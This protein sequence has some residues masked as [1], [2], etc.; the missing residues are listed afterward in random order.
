MAASRPGDMM[1]TKEKLNPVLARDQNADYLIYS[2]QLRRLYRDICQTFQKR[3][4]CCTFVTVP[5]VRVAIIPGIRISNGVAFPLAQA[6][7]RR[8]CLKMRLYDQLEVV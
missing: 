1:G 5:S 7:R 8:C 6:T 3:E 2:A 4:K